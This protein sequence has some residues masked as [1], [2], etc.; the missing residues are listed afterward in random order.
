MGKHETDQD[1]MPL[2]N[3]GE[4]SEPQ[5]SVTRPLRVDGRERPAPNIKSGPCFARFALPPRPKG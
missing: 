2:R 1:V 3:M 4:G 5:G